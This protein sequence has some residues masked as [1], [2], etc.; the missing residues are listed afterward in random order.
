MWTTIWN[1]IQAH[2][3]LSSLVAYYIAIAFAG[4]L[5]APRAQSSQFYLFVFKFVNTLAGNLTRAYASKVEASPN[6]QDAVNLVNAQAPVEK[7]V[8]VVNPNAAE[9]PPH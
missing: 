2:D 4:S 1:F 8:V 6:F 3:T 5:P 7:P 9:N